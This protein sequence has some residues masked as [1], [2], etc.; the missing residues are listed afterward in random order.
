MV[1]FNIER[2]H[3]LIN[4]GEFVNFK[5]VVDHNKVFQLIIYNGN[6]FVLH[7]I[8]NNIAIPEIRCLKK[9]LAILYTKRIIYILVAIE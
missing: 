6:I 3:A 5:R 9:W 4:K 1:F 7:T 8:I 2:R